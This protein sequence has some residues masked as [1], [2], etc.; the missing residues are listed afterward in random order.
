MSWLTWRQYRAQAWCALA[1]L[2]VV[3]VL[4][5]VTGPRL[6]GLYDTSGLPGCARTGEGC[7]RAQSAFAAAVGADGLL[8]GLFYLGLVLLLVLPAG[9]GMF[10]GVPLAARDLESGAFRLTWTQGV[11][12]TRWL[13]VRLALVGSAVAALAGLLSLAV[14]WW[15][16]PLDR[17]GALPGAGDAGLPGRFGP[18]VFAAH[19][20]VPVGWALFGFAAGVAAGLLLRRQVAAMAVVLGVLAAAQ[21]LVPLLVRPHLAAPVRTEAPLVLGTGAGAEQGTI[22]IEGDRLYVSTPV[23]LP[24]AWVLSVAALDPAGRAF[25][26]PVPAACHP[27][28]GPIGACRQAIDALGLTQRVAYQPARRYWAFQ[29]AEAGAL[30]LL[31][32]AVAAGTAARL[33][34]GVAP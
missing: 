14:S 34:R 6:A 4:Y 30:V 28:A 5:G 11:P 20:A 29:W 19:G 25:T 32:G 22:R 2:A 26:G 8:T 1:A 31:S 9:A 27:E 24:G 10:A 7:E 33:R 3:A 18:L 13:L 12:R 23:S 15:A 21:V 17:A 16:A